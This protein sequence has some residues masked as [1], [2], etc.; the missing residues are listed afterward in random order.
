[1]AKQVKKKL[2]KS[3]IFRF[4]AIICMILSLVSFVLLY[5]IGVL[6][7]KYLFLIMG[8][9]VF[10]NFIMY[11]FLVSKKWQKRMIGSVLCILF[12]CAFGV[13]IFYELTTLNFFEKAFQSKEKIE[14]YQV[15]VLNSSNYG[16]LREFK[17]GKIGV[18]RTNFSE[19][20]KLLQAEVKS[21]TSLTLQET[22]NST[23]VDSLLN[24]NLRVI[25]MEETQKN[26]FCEINDEFKENIKVLE[27]IPIKIKNTKKVKDT[28]ITKQPF[29]IYV[30]GSD[31]Y[32][33]VN[34]VSRS[35]V[36]MIV[37]V[38][39]LTHQILLTSIPRDYYVSLEGLDDA[40]DKIT[41]ASL[42]G[43]DTSV[44]TLEKL[45]DISIDYYLKINFSSLVNLVEAVDGIEVESEEAFVAHYYDEPLESWVSYSFQKGL[46]HLNGKQ[47]LAYSRERKSFVLGD[48]TRAYHQQQVLSALIKKVA[49]PT[50]LKNYTMILN[51]LDGSFDTDLS[52]EE[53]MSF[54]Q[55]QIDTGADWNISSIVL[56][57]SDA[58]KHVY[59]M[60]GV[61][62]YVMIPSEESIEDAKENIKKIVTTK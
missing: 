58:N 9:I 47:A 61:T 54:I 42:Y 46:N 26:L 43:I 33:A 23:L 18:P 44:K 28:K 38:N 39:P 6:P 52:F 21:R 29:S 36:N 57:G 48:R 13:G 1:M 35:D 55:K 12:S 45:L 11:R 60:S 2:K 8:V 25:V 41:H 56:E 50:I 17:N 59:S 49:S 37:T 53:I 32:G 51:A 27:T 7:W 62:T 31:D 22:D 5:R 20:A 15:L 30:S 34:Q 24:K 10:L 40:K 3:V 4:I 14:N 19:G 16:S